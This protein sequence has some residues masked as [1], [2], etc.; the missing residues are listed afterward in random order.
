[1]ARAKSRPQRKVA[2]TSAPSTRARW[3]LLGSIVLSAAI[4]AAWFPASALLHQRSNLT[5]ASA[6]LRLM[7]AQD[8]AL[9]Q[10]RKNLNASAEITRLAREQYQ[11]VSPG[12]QPYEVLPPAGSSG[13]T[14]FDPVS[15]GPVAPSTAVELPPGAG[16]TTVPG[17]SSGN[18]QGAT[19]APESPLTR[20]L[21]ALEFWR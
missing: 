9:A 6:Q 10:E 5:S 12:Q 20:M 1:M 15:Q 13:G 19:A 2:S 7:H 4:L 21:R 8:A 16:T 18:G 3:V 14:G 11:L 17:H